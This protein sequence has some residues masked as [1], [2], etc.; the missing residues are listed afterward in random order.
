MK[1]YQ[2]AARDPKHLSF[3]ELPNRTCDSRLVRRDGAAPLH[4]RT[5]LKRNPQAEAATLRRDAPEFGS[6][7]L[8]DIT[9]VL[10]S[11]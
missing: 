8:L 2:I 5:I 6:V 11:E 10:Q 9:K 1:D 4:L 3:N 7:W